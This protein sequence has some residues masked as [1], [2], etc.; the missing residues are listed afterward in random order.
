ME[1]LWQDLMSDMDS[2]HRSYHY[3]RHIGILG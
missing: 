3:V 1:H 2:D